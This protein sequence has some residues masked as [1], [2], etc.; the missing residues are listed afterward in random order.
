MSNR[1]FSYDFSVRLS[2]TFRSTSN[3]FRGYCKRG[4]DPVFSLDVLPLFYAVV[5]SDSAEGAIL[6]N[7]PVS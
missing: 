1:I 6:F 5:E 4:E 2:K 7:V 3:P